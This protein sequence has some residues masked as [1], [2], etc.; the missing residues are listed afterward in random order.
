ML[1]KICRDS[2]IYQ[3]KK[4]QLHIEYS[5]QWEFIKIY[6]RIWCIQFKLVTSGAQL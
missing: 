4:N 2:F 5:K 1:L 6:E 3:T